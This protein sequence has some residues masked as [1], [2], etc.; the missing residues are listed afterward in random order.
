MYKNIVPAC[1]YG[2][3][4][5]NCDV[6]TSEVNALINEVILCLKAVSSSRPQGELSCFLQ[7]F[8]PQHFPEFPSDQLIQ[9]L[10]SNDQKP[11]KECLRAFAGRVKREPIEIV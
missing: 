3:S 10:A 5:A 7:N 2:L 6:P 8:L 11:A 1:F 9:A 4:K